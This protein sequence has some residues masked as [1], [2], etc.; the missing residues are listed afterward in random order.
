MTPQH[1]QQL[2]RFHDG[3]LSARLDAI[4]PLGWGVQ[5]V[6]F[7]RRALATGQLSLLSF[8][9]VLP[10]GTLLDIGAGDSELP[11]SRPIADAFGPTRSKLE[12]F[13]GVPVEREGVS[14]YGAR[15]GGRERYVI[16]HRPVSDATGTGGSVDIPLARRN[17]CF[18]LGGESRDDFSAMPIAEIVRDE[19]GAYVVLETFVPPSLRIDASPFVMAGLRRI[20]RLMTT[21]QRAL[22]EARRERDASSV[23]FAAQDVSRYLLLSAINGRLPVINHFA[24][25]GECDPRSLFLYLSELAG[26]LATFATNFDPLSLP[27]YNHLDLRATYEELYARLTFLLQSSIREHFIAWPLEGRQ[28]GLHLAQLRDERLTQCSSFFLAVKT[29][30]PEQH[31]ATT[32]PRLSKLASWTDINNILAAATPGAPVEVTFRPPAEI[33]IKAGTLYFSIATDNVYWRNVLAERSLAVFLP[34]PFVAST[35]QLQLLGIPG[36]AATT[37]RA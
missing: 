20:L 24:E 15:P 18:L 34:D 26:Q 13:I 23:E 25:T 21:R 8:R 28:D 36:G 35:T 4:A 9:G 10:D 6:E 22:S 7:D 27:K 30:L 37:S 29:P 2:D 32:L 31:T 5:H 3:M 14:N 1:L 16:E 17:V 11:P 33:P 19:T 12:V